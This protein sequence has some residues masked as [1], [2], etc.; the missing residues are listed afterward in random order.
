VL[1]AVLA[2]AG[3]QAAHALSYRLLV[4]GDHQ[5]AEYLAQTGHGYLDYLTLVLALATAVLVLALVL[6]VRLIAIGARRRSRVAVWPLALLPPLLFACQEH[7]ERL[8]HDGAFPWTAATEATFALGLGLQVPF[9]LGAYVVVRLLLRVASSIGLWLA[10]TRAP[11][12]QVALPT[13][14][15]LPIHALRRPAL[16][17]GYGTRGPPSA[18][19]A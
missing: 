9:A 16:A 14:C 7:I 3:S 2:L 11:L 19:T 17:L 13:W 8:A 18:S 6:E 4:P 5:R 1:S 15:S 12:A 10:P